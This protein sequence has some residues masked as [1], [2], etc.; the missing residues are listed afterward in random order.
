MIC[1][2]MQIIIYVRCTIYVCM[3]SDSFTQKGTYPMLN[4][5]IKHHTYTSYIDW[6]FEL[7]KHF[8]CG[9]PVPDDIGDRGGYRIL[10]REG[11]G[12]VQIIGRP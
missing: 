1:Y 10:L 2:P 12:G 6:R 5:N 8:S 11:A 7:E 9:I 4:Y 3:W